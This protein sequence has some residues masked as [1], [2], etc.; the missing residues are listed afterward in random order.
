MADTTPGPGPGP[1]LRRTLWAMTVVSLRADRWR[2][3]AAL[4]LSL[5]GAATAMG[6]TWG[7]ARI[8]DAVVA[9]DV[10]RAER[11]GVL[12]AALLAASYA[13][14]IFM[15]NAPSRFSPSTTSCGYS[16]AA[17]ISPGAT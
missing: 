13:V 11:L 17:S 7:L 14:G 15:P 6:A 3:L 9:G 8:V 2:M 5:V 16:P 12:S 10:A 4:V 1:S